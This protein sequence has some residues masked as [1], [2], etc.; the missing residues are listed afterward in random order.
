MHRTLVLL[1]MIA[2]STGCASRLLYYPSKRV[3]LTPQKYGLEFEDVTFFSKDGTVLSGWFVPAKG[4]SLGTVVHFH[5]NAQNMTAH[6]PFVSW[7]PAEGFNVFT[8]DYRGYGRSGATPQR[9]G[10]HE[11]CMAAMEY[12][13]A[14][15]DV[16]TN[17]VF[18]FGQSLGGANALA[19]LGEK[20]YFGVKGVV[21]DSAFFS[22][23]SIVRD[24]IGAMPIIWLAKWPLSFLLISNNHSPGAAVRNISP[25]PLLLIHGTADPVVPYTHGEALYRKALEPK[26]LLRVEGGEHADALMAASATEYRRLVLQFFKAVSTCK[27]ATEN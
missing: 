1:V 3:F 17:A 22:Y 7:L 8:F 9:Q 12:I 19:V 26:Q 25:T 11:D 23:R 14:R 21:I 10:I 5:G 27:Q 24:K 20:R 6:F 4:K 13:M 16:Y 2:L 18:V 15:P